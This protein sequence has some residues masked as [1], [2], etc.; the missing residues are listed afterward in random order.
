MADADGE[1]A[2]AALAGGVKRKVNNAGFEDNR[3]GAEKGKK[4]RAGP[5]P[6]E[7]NE[8]YSNN[9]NMGNNEEGNSSNNEW[10]NNNRADEPAAA[11]PLPP[12]AAPAAPPA[13]PVPAAVAQRTPNAISQINLI[14]GD[15]RTKRLNALAKFAGNIWKVIA[16]VDSRH[17][18]GDMSKDTY[19]KISGYID[20]LRNFANNIQRLI[21]FGNDDDAR[22]LAQRLT[23]ICKGRIVMGSGP[24]DA[25]VEYSEIQMGI[26][27]TPSSAPAEIWN[28][29]RTSGGV[30]TTEDW[31]IS[32]ESSVGWDNGIGGVP[33]IGVGFKKYIIP[34]TYTVNRNPN[35][36]NSWDIS[37]GG[38]EDFRKFHK[39]AAEVLGWTDQGENANCPIPVIIDTTKTLH[40][41]SYPYFLPTLPMESYADP[42]PTSSIDWP[43]AAIEIGGDRREYIINDNAHYTISSPEG[44]VKNVSIEYRIW[45]G[46]GAAP[47]PVATYNFGG[48]GIKPN[49]IEVCKG[50]INEA[51]KAVVD[52]AGANVPAAYQRIGGAAAGIAQQIAM[53]DANCGIYN[54]LSY[55]PPP[56]GSDGIVT[57]DMKK[58]IAIPFLAKR[59]GD[60]GQGYGCKKAK[61]HVIVRTRGVRKGRGRGNYKNEHVPIGRD[62]RIITAVAQK[63]FAIISNYVFW[64]YD[65]VAAIYAVS[66]GITTVLQ[67]GEKNLIIYKKEGVNFEF[68]YTVGDAAVAALRGAEGELDVVNRYA[69]PTMAQFREEIPFRQEGDGG[70]R[71]DGF[72]MPIQAGGAEDDSLTI[73]GGAACTRAARVIDANCFYNNLRELCTP[74]GPLYDAFT[75]LNIVSYYTRVSVDIRLSH[76]VNRIRDKQSL[77]LCVD[78]CIRNEP[79][80]YEAFQS[81]EGVTGRAYITNIIKVTKE[82]MLTIAYTIYYSLLGGGEP[83][84][85]IMQEINGISE[86][87]DDAEDTNIAIRLLT[88]KDGGESDSLYKKIISLHALLP[89]GNINNSITK[90]INK[91]RNTV[92]YT[93]R[94]I[95]NVGGYEIAA[96]PNPVR[97]VAAAANQEMV[98]PPEGEGAN[99]EIAELPPEGVDAAA[100]A[101]Q[102]MVPPPEGEGA[103]QEMAE[104][105]PEEAD[106]EA[107]IINADKAKKNAI[108]ADNGISEFIGN[109]PTPRAAGRYILQIDDVFIRYEGGVTINVNGIQINIDGVEETPSLMMRMRGYIRERAVDLE[110]NPISSALYL[111]RYV[112]AI[113]GA[114]QEGGGNKNDP[115]SFYDKWESAQ[116]QDEF[117]VAATHN[118]FYQFIYLLAMCENLYFSQRDSA[119]NAY[120][121]NS[122]PIRCGGH[123]Q[124]TMAAFIEKLVAEY[125]A[126]KSNPAELAVFLKMFLHFP[127]LLKENDMEGLVIDIREYVNVWFQYATIDAK[128]T[129]DAAVKALFDKIKKDT[130]AKASSVQENLYGNDENVANYLYTV[131][132]HGFFVLAFN[133]IEKKEVASETVVATATANLLLK[134]T[135]NTKKGTNNKRVPLRQTFRAPL[136]RVLSIPGASEKSVPGSAVAGVTRKR[137]EI[138]G[139]NGNNGNNDNNGYAT[140]ATVNNNAPPAP[141]A[142]KRLWPASK[143]EGMGAS[144]GRS[145]WPAPSLGQLLIGR[146]KKRHTKKKGSRRRTIKINRRKIHTKK[147]AQKRKTR[148]AIRKNK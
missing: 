90:A 13:A 102:E 59:F 125:N 24:E 144:S 114:D 48:T 67:T 29:I 100:A 42:S 99:Q 81:W 7:E 16:L 74:F 137:A 88:R 33:T 2:A 36:A 121:Y 96:I 135:N 145:G 3:R 85:A 87:I 117:N 77:K 52:A 147:R 130:L 65:R 39:V 123:T 134:P 27:L 118:L 35:H 105:P 55:P 37:R 50:N 71:D 75:L 22:A 129:D 53:F 44:N 60:Q 122:V 148:H 132:P 115:P 79:S 98:P 5:A 128:G 18:F 138:T 26:P 1:A 131:Y 45:N 51:V 140:N 146:G 141:S 103:N 12:A 34:A 127:V 20:F 49:A 64:T 80:I 133:S 58:R 106:A 82:L 116:V 78:R 107:A 84:N 63:I 143:N 17:D 11:P 97:N 9:N 119:D 124:I 110:G 72:G 46:G 28:A 139:N 10:N 21:L 94:Y 69:A 8:E 83:H 111:S 38:E 142:A 19:I 40:K 101:N 120:V 15:E 41:F 61:R 126:R 14:L 47:D 70:P 95:I 43:Y 23:S 25:F 62:G 30:R 113:L 91:I 92:L 31:C 56:P 136:G 112:P 66:L 89:A 104:A 93:N 32:R 4:G 54:R 68:N 86:Q 73:T 76:I 109:I 57:E 6:E 108:E